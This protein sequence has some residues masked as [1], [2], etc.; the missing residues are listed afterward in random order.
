MPKL[1]FEPTISADERPQTNAV[2][3]ADT[4]TGD[5]LYYKSIF[6]RFVAFN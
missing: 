4:G 2:D 1:G 6:L 3:R 5:T